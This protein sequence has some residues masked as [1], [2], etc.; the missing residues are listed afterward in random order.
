MKYMTNKR[1]RLSYT[2][3]SLA[4][5][6]QWAD[7]INM[8]NRVPKEPTPAMIDGSR[9]HKEIE[10]HIMKFNTFPEW[11]FSG[12][13]VL[14]KVEEKAVITYNDLYDISGIFDCVDDATKTLYEFKTGTQSST[15][16]AR[17]HQIPMY[18]MMLGRL[19][20]TVEKAFLIHYNQHTK[21]KDWVVIHNSPGM[22]AKAENYIE[23]YGSE[24]LLYL[25][26][27]GLI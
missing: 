22:V 21:T 2:M 8:L 20:R 3:L 16:W 1:L 12:G 9:I 19:G 14:P 15:D 5:K 25:Q 10:E 26:N 7:L 24:I 17:T 4:E 27:E 13:L 11:L 23:T 6:G 18:F